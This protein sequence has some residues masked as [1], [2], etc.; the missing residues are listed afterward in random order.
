MLARGFSYNHK[1]QYC[2]V[3]DSNIVLCEAKI[4]LTFLLNVCGEESLNDFLKSFVKYPRLSTT[5]A[6]VMLKTGKLFWPS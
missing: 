6:G 3:D 1:S 5:L 2:I 4:V